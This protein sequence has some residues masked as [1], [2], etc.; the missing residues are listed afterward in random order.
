MTYPIISV[1]FARR[2]RLPE[3]GRVLYI[4]AVADHPEYAQWEGQTVTLQD[5]GEVEAEAQLIRSVIGGDDQWYGVILSP[6]R[7][8]S[9]DVP[10]DRY[11][12]AS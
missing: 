5:E 7:D 12:E 10:Q 6:I 11:S 1:D 2:D 8:I 9:V 3:Y 4:G